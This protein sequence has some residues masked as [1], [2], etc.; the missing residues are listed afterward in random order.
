MLQPSVREQTQAAV[1]YSAAY[2]L[3]DSQPARADVIDDIQQAMRT[4]GVSDAWAEI[5]V[6]QLRRGITVDDIPLLEWL[7][8]EKALLYV[9][10]LTYFCV[11][12][13]ASVRRLTELAKVY[14][15]RARFIQTLSLQLKEDLLLTGNDTPLAA[16]EGFLDVPNEVVQL[17][18][19]HYHGSSTARE[20]IRSIANIPDQELKHFGDIRMMQ[21]L[22]EAGE[23]RRYIND[24]AANF[25]DKAA[26]ATLIGDKIQIGPKQ[27]PEIWELYVECA[28]FVG[29]E[30]APDLF[31]QQGW[32]NAEAAGIE[33]PFVTINMAGLTL[34][35]KEELQFLLAHELG[36]I[37][38]KHV[39]KL[40][41][42]RNLPTFLRMIPGASLIAKPLEASLARWQQ[43]AELSADRIGL[44]MVEDINVAIR[45]LMKLSGV[46]PKFYS[47]MNPEAFLEQHEEFK[48]LDDDTMGKSARIFSQLNKSHPW[49]VVRA[50]VLN[51][52]M[53]SGEYE[54]FSQA[55]I[56]HFAGTTLGRM[57]RAA[58][59][60]SQGRMP[61]LCPL[62]AA[63][64]EGDA[65][66]CPSCRAPL[67]ESNRYQSCGQC[68]ALMAPK[69]PFCLECTPSV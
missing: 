28:H 8:P 52:W 42:S 46:P 11:R 65:R 3:S 7:N 64:V 14:G 63:R 1:F 69:Q 34:L 35:E 68:H 59:E 39:E 54:R 58:Q 31:V 30:T 22:N 56:G 9:G 45:T 13:S 16:L 20:I 40:M 49:T 37:R 4:E 17:L 36:H 61:Y 48:T 51:K 23:I 29:F 15:I 33:K 26:R 50:A 27:F 43:Y 6:G 53:E 24:F 41:L 66:R 12:V 18:G 62:C 38:F 10:A 2:L 21:S 60:R 44:L 67:T 47:Q 5:M 55:S 19:A 32:I 57:E 25:M